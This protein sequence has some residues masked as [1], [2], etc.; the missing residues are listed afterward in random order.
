MASDNSAVPAQ[1]MRTV[2]RRLLSG[3]TM[4][5]TIQATAQNGTF[6]KKIHRHDR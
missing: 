5:V 4:P 6:T 1:S 2:R 3:S